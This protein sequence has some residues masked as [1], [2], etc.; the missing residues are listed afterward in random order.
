MTQLFD[1]RLTPETLCLCVVDSLLCFLAVYLL[2]SSGADPG[3]AA[4]P[5]RPEI[6]GAAAA[7][8]LATA[9]LAFGIGLYRPEIYLQ[10]RRLLTNTAV[11]GTVALAGIWLV[12]QAGSSDIRLLAAHHALL[13][14]KLLA[15]WLV[16]LSATHGVFSYALRMNLFVRRLLVLGTPEE[17]AR[18]AEAVRGLCKKVFDVAAVVP[19]AAGTDRQVAEAALRHA[20]AGHGTADRAR[21]GRGKV[22][23]IVVA[24]DVAGLHPALEA[25][26]QHGVRVIGVGE[27][28]DR[29]LG[30]VDLDRVRADA[31]GDAAVAE[32][33]L[34]AAL[35][36][37][38]D[39][40]LAGFL[41]A[42]TLPLMALTAL[43]IKL[44][45]PGPLFYLQERVGR[46]GRPFRIIKFR[47]M[48]TDAEAG[49]PVWA[50]TRDAR[51]TRVGA[52]IRLTRIDELPQ[53]I[54]ILRGEMSLIGPRPER[55]HFVAQLAEAIPLYEE[56]SRVKPG[57][58]GWAQINFPYGASIEETR[59]KLSYD[60]YYVQHRS[61][62]LDLIILFAT[63]RVVL[64]QEGAR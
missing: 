52:F 4:G 31:F 18:A 12:V 39:V 22:W 61:L 62:L 43:L 3:L 17:A 49:G 1:H 50:K 41:L 11:G 47:S 60:L 32:D 64:F 44:D 35:R 21:A 40:V 26:R 58:T 59:M 16:L 56:R 14:V 54:N 42:F 30:R 20:L 33:R 13:P 10:T 38:A 6:A 2:A 24:G 9:L 51:V 23:G 19:V 36:R 45:S 5:A 8:A 25:C 37:A 46:H 34:A 27:L 53:F 7:I 48:R 63:V 29:Y 28:W 15:V 57:L 55:P